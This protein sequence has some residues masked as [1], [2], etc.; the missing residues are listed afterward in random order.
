MKTY[1][2][3]P[4]A[5]LVFRSGRPFGESSRD[6][7]NFP[8]SSSVA[9]MLRTVAMDVKGWAAKGL[10]DGQ[11][12]ELMGMAAAGP[13][14]ARREAG[15]VMPMFPKPADA[16]YLLRESATKPEVY[17]LAPGEYPEGC[18]S[19]L[20]P[21]L[22]PV[23]LEENAP[24]SK[25]QKGAEYWTLDQLLAWRHNE[26]VRFSNLPENKPVVDTRTNVAIDRNTF[27]SASGKLF[28][29]EAQDFGSARLKQGGFDQVDW[30]LLARF[31]EALPEQAV[32][33]GGERRLSWLA[34]APTDPL[35]MPDDYASHLANSSGLALTLATPALFNQGWK[36]VWLDEKLEGNFPDIPGLRLRLKAA[37]IERWQGISGWDLKKWQP[38]LARKAVAAGAT[39]WFEII[40]T[41]PLDWEQSLWLASI[42]DEKQNRR[43]GFGMVIAGS[44]T[45]TT[46]TTTIS[47]N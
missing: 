8:W 28:Q 43:D 21:G 15:Q 36:P 1:Q 6:G 10:T 23:M 12:N 25:P 13:L 7:A 22:S 40:G 27:A 20:P 47:N 35:A 9:G 29:I 26:V 5:P 42:S 45:P 44:W 41:P 2:I 46:T 32:T 30:L 34:S 33:L 16:L 17:R 19:D 31:S 18:H 39:Y 4:M 11:Q 38:K 3:D 37:A 24:K 14:L